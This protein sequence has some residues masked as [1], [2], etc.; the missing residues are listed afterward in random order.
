M[1]LEKTPGIA[2]DR[3]ADFVV[4]MRVI[5]NDIEFGVMTGLCGS[6]SHYPNVFNREDMTVVTNIDA[7]R[8]IAF[9]LSDP[10]GGKVATMDRGCAQ[11]QTAV[12]KAL[13][14]HLI[15]ERKAG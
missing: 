15:R 12:N 1:L 3:W 4:P 2:R 8:L 6:F 5:R 11:Y 10:F 13:R 14:E 9:V 7:D